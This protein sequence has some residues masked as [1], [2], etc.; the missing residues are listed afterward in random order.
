VQASEDINLPLDSGEEATVK[1]Y[2]ATFS[3]PKKPILI[4]FTEG[5]SSRKPF[6]KLI[7]EFNDLGY[8]FWQVDL[9]DSYF[10]ER[11]PTNVR[12]LSGEGVAAVLEYATKQ[13]NKTG[14]FF[15]PISTGR[16]SLILLRGSRLWQL[17]EHSNHGVGNL[18][19][20]VTFFP[21]FFDAPKKAGDAPRLFP[22]VASTSLPITLVQPSEGTYKWK[23][24]HIIKALESGNTK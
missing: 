8:E 5:Y 16:M 20:V 21:N 9:L 23:L 1:V 19:Q 2:P 7:S 24:P 22:I 15:V 4:W 17:N 3:E 11:T 12:R 6:K 10:L 13:T 18:K 14:K